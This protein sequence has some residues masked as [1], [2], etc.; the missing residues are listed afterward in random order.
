MDSAALCMLLRSLRA[1]IKEL[2]AR[3]RIGF[4]S[5]LVVIS[6]FTIPPLGSVL[7]SNTL[8]PFHSFHSVSGEAFE[9]LE[10]PLDLLDHGN[11]VVGIAVGDWV[12]GERS[13]D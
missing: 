5:L 2:Q 11:F 3:R 10:T 7:A 13:R 9:D 6:P 1:A 8:V 4:L 12:G